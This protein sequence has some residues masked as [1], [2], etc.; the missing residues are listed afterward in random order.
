MLTWMK[1]RVLGGRCENRYLERE[2]KNI[3]YL[4]QIKKENRTDNSQEALQ[5]ELELKKV[6]MQNNAARY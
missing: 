3:E 2:L 1:F 5:L 4:I 6:I